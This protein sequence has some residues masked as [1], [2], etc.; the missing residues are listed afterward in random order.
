[1]LADIA[2]PVWGRKTFA[3]PLAHALGRRGI[4]YGWLMVALTFLY[5]VCSA[6]AMSIPGVLLTPMSHDLGWSIG[7]LSGPCIARLN[8][9]LLWRSSVNVSG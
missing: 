7:E 4:H 9:R 2:S 3:A 8:R 5:G 1:M 6:G